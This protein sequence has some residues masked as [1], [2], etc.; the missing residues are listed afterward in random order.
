MIHQNNYDLSSELAEQGL[1]TAPKL[2]QILIDSVTQVERPK[3]LQ[4]EEY[5]RT[6]DRKGQ[7]NGHK[8]K[9]V[10]TRVGKITFVIPQVREGGFLLTALEKG[11]RSGRALVTTL[12]EMYVNGVPTRKRE[13]CGRR[14]TPDPRKRKTKECKSG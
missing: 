6:E 8:P 9:T 13:S 10:Q 5:K 14:F 4:A 2:M 1:E 12:K 7:A 11:L 3:Y